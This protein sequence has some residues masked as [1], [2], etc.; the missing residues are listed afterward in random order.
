M[1]THKEKQSERGQSVFIT[2]GPRNA[3]QIVVDRCDDS[4]ADC[5]WIT[6]SQA[7]RGGQHIGN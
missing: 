1:V 5:V 2:V 6:T 7:P 3:P 4:V